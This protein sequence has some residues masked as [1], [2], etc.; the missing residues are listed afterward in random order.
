M[1]L[2]GKKKCGVSGRVG[3]LHYLSD[4]M[5]FSTSLPGKWTNAIGDRKM[6]TKM[7]QN[8]GFKTGCK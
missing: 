2:D 7:R 3:G 1:L 4:M 6:F 5:S 8:D